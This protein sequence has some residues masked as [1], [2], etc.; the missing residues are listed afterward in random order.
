MSV[1]V[2]VFVAVW[3]EVKDEVTVSVIVCSTVLVYYEVDLNEQSIFTF[4]FFFRGLTLSITSVLTQTLV[5]VVGTT[6]VLI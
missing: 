5:Y 3:T 4:T 2:S 1:I 6:T